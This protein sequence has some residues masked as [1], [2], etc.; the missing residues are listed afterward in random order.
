MK[1]AINRRN[2]TVASALAFAIGLM[3]RE[4]LEAI[5]LPANPAAVEDAIVL[6]NAGLPGQLDDGSTLEHVE[7]EGDR[8]IYLQRRLPGF[9]DHEAYARVASSRCADW[10]AHLR[11]GAVDVVETRYQGDGTTSSFYMRR[12]ECS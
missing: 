1:L 3:F 9:S 7:R 2:A 11:S 5:A 12:A 10:R 8:V 6:A 4:D